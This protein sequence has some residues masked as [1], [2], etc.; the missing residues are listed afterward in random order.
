VVGFVCGYGPLVE[1]AGTPVVPRHEDW[2][3]IHQELERALKSILLNTK[4]NLTV[5]GAIGCPSNPRIDVKGRALNQTQ[6]VTL[7]ALLALRLRDTSQ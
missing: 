5:V 6:R 1:A 3:G 7:L 2:Y 4:R